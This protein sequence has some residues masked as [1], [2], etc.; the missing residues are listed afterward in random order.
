MIERFGERNLA[1]FERFTTPH[2]Q[3]SLRYARFSCLAAALLIALACNRGVPTMTVEKPTGG[4]EA[5][6]EAYAKGN[7]A[8][9]VDAYKALKAQEGNLTFS[10]LSLS[11]ALA[12]L[13]EGARGETA[14]Q[15]ETVL[16][17]A[18]KAR[19]SLGYAL[20]RWYLLGDTHRP[21]VLNIANGLWCQKNYSLESSFANTLE[22][23]YGAS[24]ASLDFSGSPDRARSTINRWASEQTAGNIRELL[25]SGV[26][27]PATRLVLTNAMYFNGKWEYIFDKAKTKD[28]PF[29]LAPAKPIDAPTMSNKIY[30]AQYFENDAVQLVMLPYKHHTMSMAVI[31]PKAKDGLSAV[32]SSLSFED[33]QTWLDTA[34]PREVELYLPRWKSASAFELTK[35]LAAMGMPLVF[36]PD[37]ADLSG[38]NATEKLFLSAV[39]Q[40]VFIDVAEEGTEVAAATAGF[41]TAAEAPVAPPAGP[42][43][44][45]ADHPFL[46]LIVH[47]SK[48]IL[49]M[50]R[51]ANP[52]Q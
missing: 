35:T 39:L 21:Y 30:S 42:V 40:S 24:T 32:E 5:D 37:K 2:A 9:A 3:R 4:S 44:F 41:P 8:F 7:N 16:H 38:V 23:G 50:G 17:L 13:H 10:P 28:A 51:V 47:Q 22:N 1:M 45:R 26:I 20:L 48:P 12:M 36:D 46:Y 18:P 25:P 33:L 52:T 6:V 19:T 14:S 34:T 15:M 43:V 27:T 29:F 49:F 11:S 31:L